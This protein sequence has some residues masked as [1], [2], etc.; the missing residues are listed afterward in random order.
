M[1][2]KDAPYRV[3]FADYMNKLGY[4]VLRFDFDKGSWKN[5]DHPDLFSSQINQL[6]DICDWFDQFK[7]WIMGACTWANVALVHAARNEI[8]CVFALAPFSTPLDYKAP[9][10]GQQLEYIDPKSIS[11]QYKQQVNSI[12]NIASDKKRSRILKKI[13][14]F[15]P[16]MAVE[17]FLRWNISK[18]VS[19]ISEDINVCF[20]VWDQDP[21]ISPELTKPLYELK[22]WL[23]E[24]HV[25]K[26]RSHG[27]INPSEGRTVNNIA[28]KFFL[29]N[30]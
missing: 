3:E 24:L 14:L 8:K 30:L 19:E 28:E 27:Y 22:K 29:E 5:I 16:P 9:E 10:E 11:A 7:I 20:V 13:G 21:L 18:V 23:K 15:V 26:S 2:S 17:D 6:Q 1:W 12:N 25:I 4:N